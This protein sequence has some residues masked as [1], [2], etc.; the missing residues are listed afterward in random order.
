MSPSNIKTFNKFNRANTIINRNNMRN[1]I[2]RIYNNA[3]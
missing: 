1:T 2:P 3:S